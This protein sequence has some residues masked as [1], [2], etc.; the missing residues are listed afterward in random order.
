MKTKIEALLLRFVKWFVG[1]Y[2]TGHHVSKDRIRK[3]KEV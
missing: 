3:Q 2:V 1:N